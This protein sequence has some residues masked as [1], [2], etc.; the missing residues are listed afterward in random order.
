MNMIPEL[1]EAMQHYLLCSL[2]TMVCDGHPVYNLS[3]TWQ[4]QLVSSGIPHSTWMRVEHGPLLLYGCLTKNKHAKISKWIHKC[5]ATKN[6]L[7]PQ[8]FN[9]DVSRE[10]K[11]EGTH[12]QRVRGLQ[13]AWMKSEICT[14]FWTKNL[15]EEIIWKI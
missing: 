15:K 2:Q 14:K 8:S 12:E 6:K 1:K 10:N 9:F 4:L 13:Y 11:T 7:L 3:A 5:T